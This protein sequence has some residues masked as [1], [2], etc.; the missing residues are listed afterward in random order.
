M[1]QRRSSTA[2][3]NPPRMLIIS[4][5]KLIVVKVLK[6]A[7]RSLVGRYWSVGV[8]RYVTTGDQSGLRRFR[9]KSVA[10]HP[11]DTDPQA[12]KRLAN[13][14]ILDFEDIYDLSA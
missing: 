3:R 10:G 12:I 4:E 11:L 9:G 13:I 14:D 7:E 1:P 6:P 8:R 2:R 5:G